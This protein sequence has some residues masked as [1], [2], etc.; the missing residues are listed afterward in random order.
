MGRWRRVLWLLCAVVAG[1]DEGARPRPRPNADK[2]CEFP[3]TCSAPTGYASKRLSGVVPRRQWV[4]SEGGYGGASA[5]QAIALTHG[6]WISQALVRKAAADGGGHDSPKLGYEILHTNIAGALSKLKLTSEVFGSDSYPQWRPFLAWL[7]GH[8]AVGTPVVWFV[9][10]QGGAHD[11]YGLANATYDAAQP[12]FGVYS[13]HALTN[14]SAVYV[15]DVL[16]HGAVPPRLHV[17]LLRRSPFAIRASFPGS[18]FAPDGDLNLG[19]FRPFDSLVDTPLMRGNCSRAAKGE[20]KREAYPCLDVQY[21]FG[22]AIPGNANGPSLP[23]RL[24][25]SGDGAEPDTTV[26]GTK[27][28]ELKATVTVSDVSF[29]T[30]YVLFRFDKGNTAVPAESKNYFATADW[31]LTFLVAG[32]NATNAATTFTWTDPHAILSNTSVAYRAVVDRGGL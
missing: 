12:V 7:K 8:L 20:G 25:V 21:A 4:D 29:E 31:A 1:A 14:A 15:D 3:G 5:I 11:A 26:E 18:G 30:S 17:F 16:V 2:E 32:P 19:Y 6:S 27:A 28:S 9:M 23:L 22:V 10:T 24:A 13:R